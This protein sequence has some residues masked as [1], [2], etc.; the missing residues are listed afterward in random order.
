MQY[1]VYTVVLRESVKWLEVKSQ[2]KKCAKISK[3][4]LLN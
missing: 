1:L 2:F 4:S 3:E